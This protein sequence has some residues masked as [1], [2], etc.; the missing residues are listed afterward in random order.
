MISHETV[1]KTAPSNAHISCLHL[2]IT[3]AGEVC[4]V[5]SYRRGYVLCVTRRYW[6]LMQGP[7]S[8][9]T[10]PSMLDDLKKRSGL[11]GK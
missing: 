1:E 5:C 9:W 8:E 7:A 3:E 11:T 10:S 2:Q 4:M 6:V